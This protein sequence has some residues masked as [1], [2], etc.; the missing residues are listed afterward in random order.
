V[1]RAI[2]RECPPNPPR[3][4]KAA[5]AA[6]AM[7]LRLHTLGGLGASGAYLRQVSR[8]VPQR[9]QPALRADKEQI[10]PMGDGS[11]IAPSGS[12]DGRKYLGH[13]AI[14]GVQ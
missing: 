13:A 10:V 6:P 12:C 4:P 5:Q 7:S 14:M 11:V 1:T 3:A 2:S 8:F 9:A